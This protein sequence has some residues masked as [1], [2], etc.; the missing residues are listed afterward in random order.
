MPS[1]ADKYIAAADSVEPKQI[2]VSQP[3]S[4]SVEAQA[5]AEPNVTP[6]SIPEIPKVPVAPIE[7]SPVTIKELRQKKILLKKEIEK[8]G[9]ESPFP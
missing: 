4:P 3:S 1:D 7:E 5:P 6:F 9:I 2:E 8:R